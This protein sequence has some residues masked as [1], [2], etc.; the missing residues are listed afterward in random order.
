MGTAQGVVEAQLMARCLAELLGF[1]VQVLLLAG[2]PAAE[3]F[4]VVVQNRLAHRGGA[5]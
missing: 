4:A 2:K 5:P 3:G 1:L